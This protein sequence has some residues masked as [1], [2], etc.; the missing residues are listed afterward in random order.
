[1]ALVLVLPSFFDGVRM[2]TNHMRH[3]LECLGWA[4]LSETRQPDGRWSVWA[5]SCCHTI[6]AIA[7]NRHD[8]W[9]AA[10]EMAMKLTREERFGLPP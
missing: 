4:A 9:S 3:R 5:T 1:M 7:D 10:C 6:L 8:V 2:T